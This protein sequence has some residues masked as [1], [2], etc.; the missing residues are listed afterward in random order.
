MWRCELSSAAGSYGAQDVGEDW[1]TIPVGEGRSIE[2]W[3]QE[4][5]RSF[6]NGAAATGCYLTQCSA[7]QFG[8]TLDSISPE[9]MRLYAA[10]DD[11]NVGIAYFPKPGPGLSHCL[12]V[13]ERLTLTQWR[14]SLYIDGDLGKGCQ[15]TQTYSGSLASGRTAFF[16]GGRLNGVGAVIERVS[17][18]SLG[19]RVGGWDVALDASQALAV[20][21]NHRPQD[22]A[23][24]PERAFLTLLGS[25]DGDTS[26]VAA[27]QMGNGLDFTLMGPWT[28]GGFTDWS[29][30]QYVGFI[31]SDSGNA[32]TGWVGR[33]LTVAAGGAGMQLTTPFVDVTACAR[34]ESQL[35]LSHD[36]MC[37]CEIQVNTAG[38]LCVI[39]LGKSS[40]RDEAGANAFWVSITNGI[41]SLY[42]GDDTSS[43]TDGEVIRG[44]SPAGSAK[45]ADAVAS[46]VLVNPGAANNNVYQLKLWYC[47]NRMKGMVR[48]KTNDGPWLVLSSELDQQVNPSAQRACAAP[49]GFFT[50]WSIRNETVVQILNYKI[51]SLLEYEP[52]CMGITHSLATVEA[53]PYMNGW[54]QQVNTARE[55]L[56]RSG[57]VAVFGLPGTT[58]QEV[59]DSLDGTGGVSEIAL[60]RPRNVVT[61]VAVNTIGQGTPP[62]AG[63]VAARDQLIELQTALLALPNTNHV[64]HISE[65]PM[66]LSGQTML[67]WASTYLPA[68][69]SGPRTS[70]SVYA[71]TKMGNPEGSNTQ[72]AGD[73]TGDGV[74][75]Q[76]PTG[77]GR[78]ADESMADD[79]FI[80]AAP[81]L[82]GTFEFP[83]AMSAGGAGRG[84]LLGVGR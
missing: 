30:P 40:R 80:L 25:A 8:I 71:F 45:T 78:I 57:N 81:F 76:E 29:P 7:D 34:L 6:E 22:Y 74:H 24:G 48:N 46:D 61:N 63:L 44:N 60:A 69:P 56:G 65:P 49:P 31:K 84:L 33:N 54:F 59:I 43:F 32:Q 79:T 12:L 2:F 55:A 27:D 64:R 14:H 19:A 75:M 82:A 26:T 39:G 42:A 20:Y 9:V 67:S 23:A 16:F 62:P 35:L 72:I 73:F 21:G 51:T 47:G 1:G 13:V 58:V 41:T 28:G 38:T 68:V 77:H 15:F 53:S 70:F 17:V 3:L 5:D 83:P 52:Y 37:E 4:G 10:D 50:V 66:T 36:W 18:G 11:E